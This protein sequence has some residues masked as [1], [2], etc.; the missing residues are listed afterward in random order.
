M[1]ANPQSPFDFNLF[2]LSFPAMCLRCLSTP[3]AI[4]FGSR[5]SKERSWSVDPPGSYHFDALGRWLDTKMRDWKIRRRALGLGRN[6]ENENTDGHEDQ[7]TSWSYFDPEAEDYETSCMQH[8]KARYNSWDELSRLQK[9]EEWH[10]ECVKALTHEQDRHRDTRDRMERLERDV[11]SL[12]AELNAQ[13]SNEHRSM[14]LPLSPR[15][16]LQ[17]LKPSP[18]SALWD[19]DALI[20]KWRTR[21]QR[22]R[23]QQHPLPHPSTPWSAP[24]PDVAQSALYTNGIPTKSGRRATFDNRL[25]LGTDGVSEDQELVDAPGEEDDMAVDDVDASQGFLDP[26]LREEVNVDQDLAM[27]NGNPQGEG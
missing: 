22:E 19:Y 24:A 2:S 18:E 13:N 11:Q 26:E 16:A 23:S 7:H 20:A 15:T 4:S 8:L 14:S 27:A 12:Q 9:Q 25:S 5:I 17:T 10:E 3:P 1:R 6:I 21:I